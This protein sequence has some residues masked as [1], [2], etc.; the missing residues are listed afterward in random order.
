MCNFR[1]VQLIS[2]AV[3][4]KDQ[5]LK[6]A[7]ILNKCTDKNRSYLSKYF[8]RSHIAYRRDYCLALPEF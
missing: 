1:P 8:T 6:V 2:E 5:G 3:V 7:I 4:S